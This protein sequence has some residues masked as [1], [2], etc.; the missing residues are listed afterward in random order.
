MRTG[1]GKWVWKDPMNYTYAVFWNGLK[2]A[3]HAEKQ[4]S[5]E[6][7]GSQ[8]AK[9]VWQLIARLEVRWPSAG[10]P[11]PTKRGIE[12]MGDFCEAILS[13]GYY[14]SCGGTADRL[15]REIS[16]VC[17]SLY[18]VEMYFHYEWRWVV[19]SQDSWTRRI[20]GRRTPFRWSKALL[21]AA[22]VRHSSSAADMALLQDMARR[23]EILVV[24]K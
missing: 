22:R 1:T 18:E 21:A 14:G 6:T 23:Y 7:K 16:E 19:D 20:V 5:P 3:S 9:L 15:M 10:D 12:R 24:E 17:E 2:H 11:V 4:R 8:N 13:K